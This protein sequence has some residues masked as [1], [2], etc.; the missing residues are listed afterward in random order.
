[1]LDSPEVESEPVAVREAGE[2]YQPFSPFE[3]LMSNPSVGGIVSTFA[4]KEPITE[5]SPQDESAQKVRVL[6]PSFNGTLQFDPEQAKIC[7]LT[8]PS[9]ARML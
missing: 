7:P 5:L 1:M 9:M 8:D 2:T 4:E 6:F 3:A